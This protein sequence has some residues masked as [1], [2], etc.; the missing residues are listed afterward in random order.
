MGAL[1]G[2]VAIVTGA[3]RGIGRAIA[4][5]LAR[6]GARVVVNDTDA[7]PAEESAAAIGGTAHVG[8]VTE[9]EVAAA[10]VALAV[11]RHGGLDILVNNAGITRDATLQRMSDADWDLVV[12]VCLRGTFNFTRAA[13]P[14]FRER[15]KAGVEGNR[16]VVNIASINGLYGVAI[17]D[18]GGGVGQRH[19]LVSHPATSMISR[20]PCTSMTCPVT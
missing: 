7:G 6:E 17:P 11:E 1:E 16:K 13:I 20:P 14:A 4:E 3:G 10:A 15:L 19:R 12:D 2:K 8:S 18:Q 5:R 9:P